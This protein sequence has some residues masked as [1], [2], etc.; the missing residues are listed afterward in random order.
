MTPESGHAN[1][2]KKARYGAGRRHKARMLTAKAAR[3][4][5]KRL[6]LP[7]TTL[8]APAFDAC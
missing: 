1:M 2:G 3:S 5:K 7:D 6:V 8:P 4:Q